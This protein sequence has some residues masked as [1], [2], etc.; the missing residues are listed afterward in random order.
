MENNNQEINET[1]TT[2]KVKF[3][4]KVQADSTRSEADENGN[5]IPGPKVEKNFTINFELTSEKVKSFMKMVGEAAGDLV[6][7][8]ISK[9]GE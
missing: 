1:T 9:V 4:I 2:G 7:E 6:K 5:L 3:E 8:K